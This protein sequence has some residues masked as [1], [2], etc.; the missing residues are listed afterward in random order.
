MY[1]AQDNIQSLMKTTPQHEHVWVILGAW[2]VDSTQ[3]EDE[4]SAVL[5]QEN[6]VTSSG[7]G[8]YK[9]ELPY[10]RQLAKRPCVGDWTD[11]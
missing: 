3:I 9:C 10:S 1:Q 6:M 11:D 7:P 5:S 8:C 2:R 4:S